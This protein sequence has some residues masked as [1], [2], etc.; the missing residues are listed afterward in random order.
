MPLKSD[1]VNV[2][3][4][5]KFRTQIIRIIDSIYARGMFPLTLRFHLTIFISLYFCLFFLFSFFFMRIFNSSF[6]LPCYCNCACHNN[7]YFIQS[8]YRASPVAYTD[9]HTNVF[10]SLNTPIQRSH[11]YTDRHILCFPELFIKLEPLVLFLQKISSEVQSGVPGKRSLFLVSSLQKKNN[12][13]K[14]IN[15][16]L[17]SRGKLETFFF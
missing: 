16:R 1:N 11:A 10:W 17:F 8:V 15:K 2:G 13:K 7:I 12:E 3:E 6:L 4:R 14:L 5:V 9:R